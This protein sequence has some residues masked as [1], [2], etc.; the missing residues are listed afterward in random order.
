MGSE[1]LFE[2]AKDWIARKSGAEE[3]RWQRQAGQEAI[4]RKVQ[5]LLELESDPKIQI[6]I[7]VRLGGQRLVDVGAEHGYCNGSGVLLRI[8][9]LEQRAVRD[10]RL[11]KRLLDLKAKV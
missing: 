6:W 8:K 3:I 4:Q 1:K 7:K 10:K 2:K 5:A 9:R 11:A